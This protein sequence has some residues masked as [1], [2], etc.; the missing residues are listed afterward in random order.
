MPPKQNRSQRFTNEEV[1]MI[2]TCL[3]R[4]PEL[5]SGELGKSFKTFNEMKDAWE[6]IANLIAPFG[7]GA[8]RSGEEVKN[9]WIDF[10]CRT[11]KK[12][13]EIDNDING[14]GG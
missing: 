4:T 6:S 10:K 8:K 2:L 14:A 12:A 7:L 9:K 1:S 5:V 3:E 11:K 13:A